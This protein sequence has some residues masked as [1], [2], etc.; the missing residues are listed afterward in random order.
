MLFNEISENFI[1]P[2]GENFR[3]MWAAWHG[4]DSQVICYKKNK[5]T[6]HLETERLSDVTLY[7]WGN[8]HLLWA[9][10]W[11]WWKSLLADSTVQYMR[12]E[13]AFHIGNTA[14]RSS[15]TTH[16]LRFL[17]LNPQSATVSV[18]H[19]LLLLNINLSTCTQCKWET[20]D[21]LLVVIIFCLNWTFYFSQGRESHDWTFLTAT[22]WFPVCRSSWWLR[23]HCCSV[24]VPV[25]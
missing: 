9:D 10:I 4:A 13:H 20:F 19:R 24:Q 22:F 8:S 3:R 23:T 15:T 17:T 25:F 16:S 14:I 5:T 12:R 7:P 21:S 6:R 1:C 11:Q 2:L 18:S